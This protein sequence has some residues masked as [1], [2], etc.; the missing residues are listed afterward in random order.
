[1]SYNQN[2]EMSMNI[3]FYQDLKIN[4][5]VISHCLIQSLIKMVIIPWK[6]GTHLITFYIIFEEFK[7][8][9]SP[10]GMLCS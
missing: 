9:D 6:Q 1:M 10:S 7:P 3:R 4:N 5:I 8:N 2:F